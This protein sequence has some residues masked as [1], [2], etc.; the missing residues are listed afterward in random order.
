MFIVNIAYTIALISA[1]S[2]FVNIKL[3]KNKQ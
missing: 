3:K 1:I 2:I